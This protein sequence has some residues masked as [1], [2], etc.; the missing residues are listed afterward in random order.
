MVTGSS[1][2]AA[3]RRLPDPSSS[4]GSPLPQ[5]LFQRARTPP[6]M[7]ALPLLLLCTLSS[8]VLTAD[9]DEP[10]KSDLVVALAD[11]VAPP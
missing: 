4:S 11:D 3:S 1:Y 2:N 7:T 8:G 10:K 5:D 6:K 9:D